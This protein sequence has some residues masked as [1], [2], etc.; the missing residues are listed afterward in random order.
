MVIRATFEFRDFLLRSFP[1]TFSVPDRFAKHMMIVADLEHGN[2]DAIE[3]AVIAAW[4]LQSG[5]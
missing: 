3:D 5:N 2:P 1:E 4:E